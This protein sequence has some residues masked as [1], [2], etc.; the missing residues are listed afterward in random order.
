[1]SALQQ[2]LQQH[3]ADEHDLEDDMP[4]DLGQAQGVLCEALDG[5]EGNGSFCT[6]D[7]LKAL[8]DPRLT[9]DDGLP[10]KLPL[11]ERD[12]R[13]IIAASHAAPFGKG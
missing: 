11:F 12:A 1:M 9:I 10:I 8:T 2:D 7:K 3:L 4:L 5:I 13:R 6:F